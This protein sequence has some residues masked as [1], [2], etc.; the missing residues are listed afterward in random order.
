MEERHYPHSREI[1]GRREKL[2]SS[3]VRSGPEYTKRRTRRFGA[4]GGRIPPWPF[5]PA[6]RAEPITAVPRMKP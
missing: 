1:A 3:D 4:C 5:C 2:E 6:G